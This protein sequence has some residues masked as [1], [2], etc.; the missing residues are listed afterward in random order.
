MNDP[1]DRSA[2]VLSTLDQMNHNGTDA[3]CTRRDHGGPFFLVHSCLL[4]AL[5]FVDGIIIQALLLK[6]V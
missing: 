1:A 3:D 6:T 2:A 4:S 5:R